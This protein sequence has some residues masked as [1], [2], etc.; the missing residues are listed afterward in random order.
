MKKRFNC[1]LK[2]YV[3][4]YLGVYSSIAKQ[5]RQNKVRTITVIRKLL[6]VLK[7]WNPYPVRYAT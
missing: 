5:T 4:R 7:K 6:R 1:L 2:I 3:S